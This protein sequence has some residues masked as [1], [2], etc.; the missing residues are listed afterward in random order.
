MW[1]VQFNIHMAYGLSKACL[2][3]FDFVLEKI[4]NVE[5]KMKCQFIENISYWNGCLETEVFMLWF[6]PRVFFENSN[7][8]DTIV[9]TFVKYFI[10]LFCWT[11]VFVL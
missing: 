9:C 7:F 6:F 10:V 2:I 3:G 5:I 1:I 11:D 8:L 4:I